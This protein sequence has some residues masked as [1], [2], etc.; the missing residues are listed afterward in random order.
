MNLDFSLSDFPKNS[1]IKTLFKSAQRKPSCYMQTDRQKDGQTDGQMDSHEKK[2][3]TCPSFAK[4]LKIEF[5]FSEILS[6]FLKTWF[7]QTL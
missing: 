6:N 3:F 4:A 7:Y 2:I 5:Y 1:N